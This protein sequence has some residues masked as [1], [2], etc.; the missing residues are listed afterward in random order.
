MPHNLQVAM[1]CLQWHTPRIMLY[2][3]SY[4][5]RHRLLQ[6]VNP[7]RLLP[8][9]LLHS[10]RHDTCSLRVQLVLYGAAG[11]R[12]HSHCPG[13]QRPALPGSQYNLMLLKLLSQ[14]GLLLLLLRGPE[15][16]QTCSVVCLPFLLA[17]LPAQCQQLCF[18]SMNCLSTCLFENS[19]GTEQLWCVLDILQI[20]FSIISKLGCCDTPA[21]HLHP[22]ATLLQVSQ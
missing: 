13:T 17:Q 14:L 2:L 11:P 16:K 4:S 8:V 9:L 10:P 1:L 22:K 7:Q 5:Q 21:T 15:R 6:P 20:H 3:Q 18:A 19:H 12:A